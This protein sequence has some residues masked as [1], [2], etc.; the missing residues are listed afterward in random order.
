MAKISKVF[1]FLHP[2]LAKFIGA[3]LAS[4]RNA[5]MEPQCSCHE[6]VV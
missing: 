2:S 4:R 1:L 5:S 3:M 6:Y